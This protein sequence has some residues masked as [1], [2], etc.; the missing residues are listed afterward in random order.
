LNDGGDMLKYFTLSLVI[1]LTIF[2]LNSCSTKPSYALSEEG[3][4]KFIT[5]YEAQVEKL[6]TQRNQAEWDAYTTGKDEYFSLLSRLSLAIDSLH[7]NKEQFQYL[8]QLQQQG[9][10]K[11]PLLKRQLDLLYK[12]YL[13]RQTDPQLNKQITELAN[14]LENTYAN[15]R[16]EWADTIYSDNQVTQV[17]KKEKNSVVR[18][19]I[20]RAQKMLGGKVATDLIRLAGMRNQSAQELGYDNYFYKQMDLTE[21]DPTMVEKIFNELYTLT[22]QPYRQ[23]H[24]QIEEVFSKR[25]GISR[26]QLRP[27]HYEDLFA[28][29]APAIY[30]VDLDRYYA[31]VDIPEL[32]KTFYAS[33]G[34]PVE[35]ILQRSDLFE[36]PGKNQH[37]FSFDIDRRQNIRILCNIIPDIRWMETILH[38]LGHANYDKYIDQTLPFL[39]REP[40]HSFTTE[41]IA[42]LFGSFASDAAWMAAG[43]KISPVEVAKIKNITESSTRLSKLIFARWSMVVFN[44]EKSFY[45]DPEQDLNNLWWSLVEKYQLIRRPE[46]LTGNEWATKIHISTYPVYY[47]NYQLGELFAAQ[48]MHQIKEKYEVQNFWN[49]PEVGTYL[50][51]KVF[52]P[53]KKLAWPEFVEQACSGEPLTAKYFVQRYVQ[54]TDK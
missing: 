14:K 32:A 38:E 9:I 16:T 8:Q 37:A 28:Q 40:A 44:F 19:K 23:V 48:V 43:L 17:L 6:T 54:R 25:Y 1:V 46:N 24:D 35:D 50:K 2:I 22:E 31:K 51:E 15:Y 29:E 34:M 39:L 30:Q 3:L 12:E 4:Q 7:Q 13:G 42:K 18:E 41:G 45:A 52:A 20:W 10:V 49:Q 5:D 26:E 33:L 11:T 27:W 47:H 53:G 21:M 36:R